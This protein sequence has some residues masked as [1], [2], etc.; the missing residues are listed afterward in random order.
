MVV[1]ERADRISVTRAHGGVIVGSA[2]ALLF[3]PNT[4]FVMI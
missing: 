2:L 4:I 3:S 1:V